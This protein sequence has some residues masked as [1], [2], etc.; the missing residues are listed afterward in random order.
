M[1]KHLRFLSWRAVSS[2]EQADD[3]KESLPDQRN[4]N[5]I[6]VKS[7]ATYYPGYTGEIVAELEVADSRS[8]TLL[9]DAMQTYPQY[10]TLDEMIRSR[11]IDAIVC[12]ERNRLGRT[13][14]LVTDIEHLCDKYGIVVVP[15][16][17]MPPTLDVQILREDESYQWTR[18]I[19]SQFA[20]YEIR[21]LQRRFH[22]GK[23]G[24]AKK[25]KFASK[26]PWGYSY[27]HDPVTG[28]KTIV[29][30][31]TIRHHLRL[32]YLDLY[33][34]RN[35]STHQVAEHLNE[36]GILTPTG[37]RWT[38]Q[39][40]NNLLVRLDAYAG[41]AWIYR[42]S[43]TGKPLVKGKGTH[44]P[45][46][47]D[48][49][50]A[51]IRARQQ[52]RTHPGSERIYPLSS[53]LLCARCLAQQLPDVPRDSATGVVRYRAGDLVAARA[54]LRAG[55]DE[56]HNASGQRVRYYRYHCYVKGDHCINISERA[57]FSEIMGYLADIRHR[58]DTG[59]L[60]E[61]LDGFV[62]G[63]GQTDWQEQAAAL[64]EQTK[65]LKAEERRLDNAYINLAAID[66]TEYLRRKH[67]LLAR[68]ARL[69][70]AQD[71]AAGQ[72]EQVQSEN[73]KAE[74]LA[75]LAYSG[76]DLIRDYL[77]SEPGRVRAFLLRHLR[78][79]VDAGGKMVFYV[80]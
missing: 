48:D 45:V 16:T 29:L 65:R 74:R 51:L 22:F 61:L 59:R 71:A 40:V 24:R 78:I 30:D 21:T 62:Q 23:V 80:I 11:R 66:E 46:F 79:V 67:D 14:S 17:T 50:L 49:E 41:Y 53:I 3:D 60:A 68:Q 73:S 19:E 32:M 4:H 34:E 37:K 57:V 12:R 35:Y 31:E 18:T 2:E 55:R 42:T 1:G 9:S 28:E 5:E 76:E 69:A 13:F 15:R 54:C 70:E 20:A 25:G 26:P 75:T 64:A 56:Y 36:R 44:P 77:E 7:L 8:I 63:D 52:H 6:F 72:M 33:V 27:Y 39:Q 43:R 10:A 47:S 58:A 38:G